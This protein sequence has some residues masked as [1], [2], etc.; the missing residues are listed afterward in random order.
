MGDGF[1]GINPIEVEH[2]LSEIYEKAKEIVQE[3]EEASN[4]FRRELRN[5][6]ASPRAVDFGFATCGDFDNIIC[7]SLDQFMSFLEKAG[8]AAISMLEA[9]GAPTGNISYYS[10]ALYRVPGACTRSWHDSLGSKYDLS[11]CAYDV[12]GNVG[13]N[14][15]VVQQLLDDFI[16]SMNMYISKMETFDFNISI[17]DPDDSIKNFY[18]DVLEHCVID[19]ITRSI[20]S[21]KTKIN[22]YIGEEVDV[23]IAGVKD[24]KDSLYELLYTADF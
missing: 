17:F 11:F 23:V 9:N 7:Y 21:I 16:S 24:A 22:Q 13:M 12:D 5:N 2:Q 4:T 20:E 10:Q 15:K 6:W 8:T 18:K 3:V 19:E 1:T 14:T